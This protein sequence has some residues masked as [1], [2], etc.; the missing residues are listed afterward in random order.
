MRT[1]A[2]M[3]IASPVLNHDVKFRLLDAYHFYLFARRRFF[4]SDFGSP[5]LESSSSLVGPRAA[6]GSSILSGISRSSIYMGN[7]DSSL[8]SV[9]STNR[10]G[11]KSTNPGSSGISSSSCEPCIINSTC[12]WSISLYWASMVWWNPNGKLDWYCRS[13]PTQKSSKLTSYIKR[14]CESSMVAWHTTTRQSRT[15]RRLNIV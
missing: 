15:T 6:N 5:S 9:S 7:W 10:R 1:R 8:W 13:T 11:P 4:L 14:W 12:R 3:H 2:R